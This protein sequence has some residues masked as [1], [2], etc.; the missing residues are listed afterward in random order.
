[1]ET[2]LPPID[3]KVTD[4]KTIYKYLKYLQGLA[5]DANVLLVNTTL[6]AGAAINAYKVIWNYPCST[7]PWRFSFHKRKI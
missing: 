1:M 2:Y 3:S 5:A 4:L 6:D 7:A